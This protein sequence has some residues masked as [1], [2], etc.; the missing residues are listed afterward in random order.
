MGG[1][2]HW[3]LCLSESG[4]DEET[5]IS[6]Y[7]KSWTQAFSSFRK[8]LKGLTRISCVSRIRFTYHY[9]IFIIINRSLSDK[10]IWN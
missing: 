4:N 7:K 9:L 5:C 6:Q 2:G 1:L 8:A 3:L 10:I